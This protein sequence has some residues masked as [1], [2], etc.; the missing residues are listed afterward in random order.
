MI[1]FA[2]I[3]YA[4]F[5]FAMAGVTVTILGIFWSMG[6]DLPPRGRNPFAD[7][8]PNKFTARRLAHSR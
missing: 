8:A 1:L 7:P 4:L 3:F 6:R 2:N 5:L